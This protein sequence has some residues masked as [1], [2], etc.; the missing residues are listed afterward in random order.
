MTAVQPGC[1]DGGDEELATIGV[2]PGVGHAQHEWT[3]VL[4]LEVLVWEF[5]AVDGF[6]ARALY[7]QARSA[8]DAFE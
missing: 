8:I 3:A 1:D 2:R 4:E 5:L 6:T 7:S